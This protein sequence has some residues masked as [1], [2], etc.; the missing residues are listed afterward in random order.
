MTLPF[1]PGGRPACRRRLGLAALSANS[2]CTS[3]PALL[4]QRAVQTSYRYRYP[5]FRDHH[6]MGSVLCGLAPSQMSQRMDPLHLNGHLLF[7]MSRRIA[8]RRWPFPVCRY[9]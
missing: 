7:G 2:M 9:F 3:H 1:L 4:R 8:V 6:Y 5:R